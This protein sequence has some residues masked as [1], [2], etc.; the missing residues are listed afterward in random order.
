MSYTATRK[1]ANCG[2]TITLS[3][4]KGMSVNE[5]IQAKSI[6]CSNCG[7]EQSSAITF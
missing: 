5:Y 4:P 1:C 3:P 2:A 7:V 6:P